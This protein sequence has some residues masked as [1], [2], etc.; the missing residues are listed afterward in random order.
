MD[1]NEFK[2]RDEDE[3]WRHTA[4]HTKILL[5]DGFIASEREVYFAV[6]KLTPFLQETE[7]RYPT[8]ED[9]TTFVMILRGP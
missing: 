6:E 4:G 9:I 2:M 1:E 8:E 7:N 5:A 3:N